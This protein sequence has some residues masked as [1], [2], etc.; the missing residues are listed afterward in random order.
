[1]KDEVFIRGL[2]KGIPSFQEKF[3]AN[4]Y[5]NVFNQIY[6]I[7]RNQQDTEDATQITF[8]KA[9]KNIK[10]YKG[11]AALGTWLYTIARNE[12]LMML[13]TRKRFEGYEVFLGDEIKKQVFSKSYSYAS[14]P[15]LRRSLQRSFDTL[16]ECYRLALHSWLLGNPNQKTCKM[17]GWHFGKVKT[18]IQRAR[19]RMKEDFKKAAN[20]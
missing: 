8:S 11:D 17:L 10:N 5:K 6:V 9:Y 13:R 15:I 18:D 7:L 4:N 19:V 12:A 2:K 14:D 3:Y 20:E 16:P 1:V